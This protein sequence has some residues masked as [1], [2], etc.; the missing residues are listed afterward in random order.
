MKFVVVMTSPDGQKME[1][2]TCNSRERFQWI[3][4]C[5]RRGWTYSVSELKED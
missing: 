4:A 2:V 3:I 5:K 1:S